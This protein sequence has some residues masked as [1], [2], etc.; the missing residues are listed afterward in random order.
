MGYWLGCIGT[1]IFSDALY[2]L[3][4]YIS[5]DGHS[6]KKQTWMR[7]H[8]VR[9]VRGILGITLVLMGLYG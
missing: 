7:D 4:L 6:G 9:V 5:A 3:L 2:S 8:W 1:W